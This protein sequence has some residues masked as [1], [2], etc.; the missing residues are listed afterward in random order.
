MAEIDQDFKDYLEGKG[1]HLVQ[2]V[3]V[4]APV[5]FGVLREC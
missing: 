3:E 4:L 5:T 1:L 2:L